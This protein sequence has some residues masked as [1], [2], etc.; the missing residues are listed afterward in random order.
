MQ[1]FQGKHTGA[2]G[3]VTELRNGYV[4]FRCASGT[5]INVRSHDLQR[6]EKPRRTEEEQGEEAEA[7]SDVMLLPEQEAPE[8]EAMSS[9]GATECAARRWP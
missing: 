1:V 2:S 5:T 7:D 8:Q 9:V 6:D 4:F 3:V